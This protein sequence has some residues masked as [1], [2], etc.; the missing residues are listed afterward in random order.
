MSVESLPR[1]EQVDA[2]HFKATSEEVFRRLTQ[3]N[4]GSADG[5]RAL[6][7]LAVRYPPIYA[8][9][10]E[11]SAECSLTGVGVRPSPLSVVRRIVEVTFF[12]TNRNT[13]FTEAFFVRVDVTEEF[14]FVVTKLAPYVGL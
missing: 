9:T 3:T 13:N 10:A 11:K 14:P 4:T 2:G 1:A 7:Y 12:F 8:K 6:N 5:D